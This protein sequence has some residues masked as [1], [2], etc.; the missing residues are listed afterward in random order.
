MNPAAVKDWL[1]DQAWNSMQKLI[2]IE[3]FETFAQNVTEN[4]RFKDWYNELQPEEQ[5]LP[6]DWKRLDNTPFQKL[7]VIRVMR[8][9]RITTG[10]D[11][12]VGKTLP[13]GENFVNCDSTSNS[14]QI[15]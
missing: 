15:L 8:P 5:R 6:G 7:L 10:L 13:N 1:P 2:E 9:D 12:F 11:N 14:V 3:G 4:S